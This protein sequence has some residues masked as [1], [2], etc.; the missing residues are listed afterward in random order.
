MI[1]GVALSVFVGGCVSA[2]WFLLFKCVFACF[3]CDVLCEMLS[4]LCLCVLSVVCACVC[5]LMRVR[6]S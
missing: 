3:V 4:D 1:Y 6:C 2:W 5:C